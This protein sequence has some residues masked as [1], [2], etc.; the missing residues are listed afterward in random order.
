MNKLD[1]LSEWL[2]DAVQG[3]SKAPLVSQS[4]QKQQ[5]Q[6][7]PLK[8]T[9]G[10]VIHPK[11]LRA[12]PIGGLEEVGKNAMIFEY[13]HDIVVVDMGFQFPEDELFGVD[14]IIPDIQYLVQRK[15]RIRGILITHGHLDHIG[16]L[17]Y[18]LPDL[19]FPTIYGSAL[20]LGLVQRQLEEHKLLKHCRFKVIDNKQ[21]YQLGQMRVEFFRVNHSIPDA[22][23]VYLRSP[24]GNIVHTGDF[25]F[26]FTPADG[27]EADIKRMEEIGKRGVD[28]LFSDSTG[29]LKPGHTLS[30]RIVAETL[31]ETIAGAKGRIVI[32]TFSSLIGRIQ[33]VL[34]FAQKHS[35][36]VFLS[37]GS[38]EAN[39]EI[40]KK[41]GFLKFD[42]DLVRSVREVT[43]YPDRE[44]LVIST[45]GQGEPMAALSRMA[46]NAHVQ[47]KIHDGDTVVMSSSPI[48]GNEKQ[49]RF[50]VNCLA[51][52]GANVVHSQIADVHASGHA[53][54]EDLKFMM[55]L[56]RPKHLVP[57]HGDFYMR[58]A[59][60]N[61]GPAVGVPLGNVHMLDNG[62]VIEVKDGVVGFKKED[63]KVRY[64]VVDGLGTGDLGSQ[65]LKERET[66]AQNG[67]VSVTIKMTHGGRVLGSPFILLRG[68]LVGKDL[69]KSLKE[70]DKRV[71]DSVIKLQKQNKRPSVRD[72]EN[73]I[74]SDLAGY[75]VQKY[76]KRPLILPVVV[77]VGKACVLC[78]SGVK[79]VS[80][81]HTRCCA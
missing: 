56:V 3:G 68:F 17:A 8:K 74:R 77:L 1:K 80:A 32:A 27:V 70:M 21:T 15:E 40:A 19:G 54:Q 71:R 65:V 31:E 10:P 76:N 25:K 44:V 46:T 69:D 23:G 9:R 4:E 50:L 36:K 26:D 66:M 48:P 52:L 43:R 39:F 37:G 20:T 13:E 35:R 16:A 47:I 51:Q 64:V 6:Q 7:A 81:F 49:V 5:V 58:R 28:V 78:I 79:D 2:K 55:S 73:I 63:I 38:L 67:L 62:N 30:E 45:G 14:Y 75:I 41:L 12:I 24:A 22:M 53:Q 42:K 11:I 33:Q 34:Q 60:G 72:Y 29:A 61:L 59:H 18:V 57:V